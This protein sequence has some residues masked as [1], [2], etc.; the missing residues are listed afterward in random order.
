[1]SDTEE[2]FPSSPLWSNDG[3]SYVWPRNTL[4]DDVRYVTHGRFE[5]LPQSNSKVVRIFLSSTFT[6]F[7]VER[8]LLI[9]NVYPKLQKLCKEKYDL[10][11]QVSYCV[12]KVLYTLKEHFCFYVYI[13]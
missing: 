7:Y 1:M 10:D 4:Q 2:K 13:I 5:N 8:N 3:T 9:K 11:F 12:Y 6:D